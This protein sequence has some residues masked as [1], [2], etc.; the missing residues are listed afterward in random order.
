MVSI[1]SACSHH[2]AITSRARRRCL[3][4]CGCDRDE[5]DRQRQRQ[6]GQ[7]QS[8]LD[9]LEH[10]HVVA[11]DDSE[12]A[13]HAQP[14][15]GQ[16]QRDERECAEQDDDGRGLRHGDRGREDFAEATSEAPF[17]RWARCD[18]QGLCG[19]GA[20]YGSGGWK[21]DQRSDGADDNDEAL[22]EEEDD[23]LSPLPTVTSFGGS[24][25]P[26]TADKTSRANK[27]HSLPPRSTSD[28]AQMRIALSLSP[29]S[30]ERLL[31]VDAPSAAGEEQSQQ[32]D[33]A[34]TR[35]APARSV[36]RSRSASSTRSVG[37]RSSLSASSKAS[38]KTAVGPPPH[39]NPSRQQPRPLQ[40]S[41]ISM[42]HQP[43]PLHQHPR[44]PPRPLQRRTRA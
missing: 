28:S 38:R 39:R 11:G 24:I 37:K 22:E 10:E 31:D 25:S 30:R 43:R 40:Q 27:R 41:R 17:S 36:A 6:P 12:P 26:R 18:E 1:F 44:L 32:Q 16:Q 20:G 5:R 34:N 14:R 8:P 33:P 21:Q 35:Q 2:S 29:A 4:R 42:L 23:P 7:R 9:I 19:P 13:E 3:V 15:D